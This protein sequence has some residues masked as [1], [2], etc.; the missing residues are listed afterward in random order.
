MNRRWATC[1]LQ[2]FIGASESQRGARFAAPCDHGAI[3]QVGVARQE[4]PRHEVRAVAVARQVQQPDRR[5]VGDR[6]DPIERIHGLVVGQVA[7]SS[8]DA[9]LQVPRARTVALEGFV[10]VAFHAQQVDARERFDQFI[11]HGTEVGRPA[12]AA[13]RGIDDEGRAAVVVVRRTYRTHAQVFAERGL[14]LDHVEATA[15]DTERNRSSK[16]GRAQQ[17]RHAA[18]G[19]LRRPS[20]VPVVAVKVGEQDRAEFCARRAAV[21]EPFADLARAQ[22]GI[23]QH[24]ASR[25]R[26]KLHDGGIAARAAAEHRDRKLRA[27]HGEGECRPSPLIAGAAAAAVLFAPASFPPPVNRFAKVW[28]PEVLE[29]NRMHLE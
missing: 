8:H 19:E 11:V 20:T 23:E 22:A 4:Q 27:V 21:Q 17:D 18:A 6:A 16:V 5:G 12:D 14:A 15:R 24:D 9:L 26:T 2:R 28:S 7:V 13:G 1:R 10:V 29:V 3:G 25:E